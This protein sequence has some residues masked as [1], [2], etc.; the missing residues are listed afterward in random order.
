M[1]ITLIQTLVILGA[2]TSTN[3]ASLR[4]ADEQTARKGVR[5]PVHAARKG[6]ID[7]FQARTKGGEP[8]H[9]MAYASSGGYGN[10]YEVTKPRGNKNRFRE[11]PE[12]KEAPTDWG[13]YEVTKPRGNKNRFREQPKHK[14]AP[15]DWGEYEAVDGG[16]IKHG[17]IAPAPRKPSANVGLN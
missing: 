16:H 17:R 7:P 2:A 5:E 4:G 8:D 9:M 14:E 11:Q 12:H 13:E 15:T 10:E 3:A 6:V 1:K